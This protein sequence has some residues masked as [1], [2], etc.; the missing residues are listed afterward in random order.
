MIDIP[1]ENDEN[2][3]IDTEEKMLYCGY[4][5]NPLLYVVEETKT[6]ED[7]KT[8]DTRKMEWEYAYYCSLCGR[9]IECHVNE[10]DFPEYERVELKCLSCKKTFSAYKGNLPICDECMK[11]Y[12][13]Q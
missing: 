9:L 3:W 11:K 13:S 1:K 2:I 6:H 12:R 7:T 4:C 8:G 10:E 5:H